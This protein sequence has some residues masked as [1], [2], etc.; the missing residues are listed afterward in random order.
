MV[1]MLQVQIKHPG[2]ALTDKEHKLIEFLV[3]RI[4]VHHLHRRLAKAFRIRPAHVDSIHLLI[5]LDIVVE[6]G[7]S[8]DDAD[9]IR[10]DLTSDIQRTLELCE[11]ATDEVLLTAKA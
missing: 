10:S 6:D 5:N 1:E 4:C 7:L 8:G 3:M 9:L 11:I 2:T